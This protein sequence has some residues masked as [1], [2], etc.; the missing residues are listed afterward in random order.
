MKSFLVMVAVVT[1]HILGV[2]FYVTRPAD[3]TIIREQRLMTNK[4]YG[5]GYVSAA[6]DACGWQHVDP[7]NAAK[8]AKLETE[9]AD[10]PDRTEGR[11][12]WDEQTREKPDAEVDKICDDLLAGEL[13]RAFR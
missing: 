10:D 7:G 9:F 12:A 6:A 8:I 2:I 4:A 3:Q 5:F 11:L 1:L 13:A